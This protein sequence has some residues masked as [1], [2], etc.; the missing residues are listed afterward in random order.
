M[1]EN[2]LDTDWPAAAPLNSVAVSVKVERPVVVGV[3]EMK[4]NPLDWVRD[5]PAGSEPLET[6]HWNCGDVVALSEAD[7]CCVG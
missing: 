4:V 1:M 2:C 3:P 6:D 5:K 7:N